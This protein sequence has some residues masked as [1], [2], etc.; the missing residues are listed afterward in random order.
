M[1]FTEPQF[2]G[3]GSANGRGFV[4]NEQTIIELAEAEITLQDGLLGHTRTYTIKP[5][6]DIYGNRLAVKLFNDSTQAQLKNMP[7]F[8]R[9][10]SSFKQDDDTVKEYAREMNIMVRTGAFVLT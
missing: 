1:N 3:S 7:N 9:R 6:V 10:N 8:P 2:G 4:V 5:A